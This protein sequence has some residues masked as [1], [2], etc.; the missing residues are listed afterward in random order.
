MDSNY[1]TP[2][3]TFE[4]FFKNKEKYDSKW[5]EQINN[6]SQ[7]ERELEY[8]QHNL[9]ND[10]IEFEKELK[11]DIDTQLTNDFLEEDKYNTLI[12]LILSE[13]AIKYADTFFTVSM[14]SSNCAKTMQ[15]FPI[16]RNCDIFT[17][18]YLEIKLDSSFETISNKDKMNLLDGQVTLQIGGS[19]IV[20]M[21][22]LTCIFN[23]VCKNDN[24]KQSDDKIQ[25]LLFD[26]NTLTSELYNNTSPGLP[27]IA[28]PYHNICVVLKF[29]AP[30][31]CELMVHGTYL[32]CSE[33]RNLAQQGHEFLIFQNVQNE[34]D[35]IDYNKGLS[36]DYFFTK[37]FLIYFMPKEYMQGPERSGSCFALDDLFIE[38]PEIMEACLRIS[39]S[40]DGI[41]LIEWTSDN[42]LSFEVLGIKIYVLS[43]SRDMSTWENIN[44]TLKDPLKKMSFNKNSRYAD[45]IKLHVD[46][47]S[48]DEFKTVI[49]EIKPNILKV[50]NGMAG[51]AYS[52]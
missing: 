24:I 47:S 15:Y 22:I 48:T 29:N 26:F 12:D 40:Y 41:E 23:L 31:K 21:N 11:T 36:V 4:Q 30:V 7:L 33:R 43:M 6:E 2:E 49:N 16:P 44:E 37:F 5:N 27:T 51:V 38:Y 14:F 9:E 8:H 25:I 13:K 20:S 45:K 19:N 34:E 17:K 18:I 28:L 10:K 35:Y 50:C 3:Q 52:N 46:S 32:D 1:K 42:I 39:N